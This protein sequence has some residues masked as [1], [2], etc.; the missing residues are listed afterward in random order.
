MDQRMAEV[1]QHGIRV[2][3]EDRPT[4]ELFN[5]ALGIEEKGPERTSPRG[6]FPPDRFVHQFRPAAGQWTAELETTP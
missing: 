4:S 3:S 2:G 6:S 5:E 1:H